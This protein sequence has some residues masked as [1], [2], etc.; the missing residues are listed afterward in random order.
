[1]SDKPS[2]I[3]VL[4]ADADAVVC[5][6]VRRALHQIGGFIVTIA[7]DG[8]DL[9]SRFDHEPFD[10]V[11]ADAALSGKDGFQ[12]LREIK[13][14][15]PRMPVILL[16]DDTS[17]NIE[18]RVKSEG[19][20][21]L[22][23]TPQGN[24][25]QLADAITTAV[26]AVRSAKKQPPAD[27]VSD[28]LKDTPSLLPEPSATVSASAVSTLDE[29]E[30]MTSM[31]ELVASVGNLTFS[32]TTQLLL[33]KSAHL[34]GTERAVLFRMQD[35]T[36]QLYRSLGFSDQTEAA[37]D[38]VKNVG[39]LFVWSVV[40]QNDTQINTIPTLDG[41]GKIPQCVGTPILLHNQVC[42]ALV[43]YDLP[44]QPISTAQISWFELYAA[45]GGLASELEHLRVENEHLTPGDPLTGVLKRNVFLDL[46]DHEFRRS[47][48]YNQPIAA[49][50]V[51]VD[52][53]QVINAQSGRD[54]GDHILQAVA[55][56][57]RNIVRSI[58]LVGRYDD[59]SIA[60]LLLM[61]DRSGAKNA[62]ERLRIGIASLK[63]PD[64]SPDL[65][66]T[67]TLGVAPYPREACSSIYDLL[68][69]A[70]QAQRAAHR[71]G[72]NQIMVV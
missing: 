9:L 2:T 65:L 69:V 29:V 4:F 46:A 50:I 24:V 35:K 63:L 52:E 51:D 12:V 56:A 32:D 22:L 19:A 20:F 34:F 66:I 1:M 27:E 42:G 40:T 54:L 43:L 68:N 61:T 47:W 13:Q 5:I 72:R 58:D 31:R 45:Q 28:W 57:C 71:S 70:Q 55:K 8:S 60:I 49:L 11:V 3:R 67:V 18:A 17:A 26:E 37:R 10:A 23:L 41:T 14:R 44:P 64:A 62:A 36:L 16:S 25:Q 38:L 7:Y 53:M 59:D 48:R 6:S 33:E 39:D 15:N 21:A 30:C